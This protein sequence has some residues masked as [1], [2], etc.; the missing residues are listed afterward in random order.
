MGEGQTPREKETD[1]KFIVFIVLFQAK[2]GRWFWRDGGEEK[3]EEEHE[4]SRDRL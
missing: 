2:G 4:R 3:N 1:T